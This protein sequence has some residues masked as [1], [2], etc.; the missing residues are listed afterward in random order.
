M[1]GL[2]LVDKPSGISSFGA[3]AAIRRVYS[4]KRAGHTGTLDPLATGVLPVL[5]GRATRLC[6]YVTEQDKR[7]LACIRLGITTDT[8][9]ITGKVISASAVDVS[10]E[11]LGG[12]LRS[13]IGDYMQVPPMYSAIKKN[14]KKLYELARSGEEIVREPRK[15]RINFIDLIE[16]NGSD[17]TVDVGCS[18]GTY[19]RSLA[20]DIGR[21]LG[22]GAVMTAL[23]RT[24]TAGFSISECASL[25]MI[26]SD[27]KRFLLPAHLA[28]P[29][30]GNIN[31]TAKQAERFMNGGEL[32]ADRINIPDCGGETFKVFGNKEFLG[33][34]ELDKAAGLLRV[35][36]VIA[37]R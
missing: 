21:A 13:V 30:F 27:P 32:S 6:G 14:G 1:N 19:I 20:D 26:E 16:R 23:R 11:E 10:D 31:I 29:Q 5:I 2:I 18:K 36:C 7:Y 9:D 28:V 35:K 34:G 24:E 37:E 4:E 22:C 3:V 17:L 8:L 33:L 15:V 12:A 25:E